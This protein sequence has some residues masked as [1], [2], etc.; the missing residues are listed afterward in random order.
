M[1]SVLAFRARQCGNR[2]SIR[3]EFQVIKRIVKM[4]LHCNR[5]RF[6]LNCI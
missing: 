2:K 6:K 5:M 1:N 3:F 4:H